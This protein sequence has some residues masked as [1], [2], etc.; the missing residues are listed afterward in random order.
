MGRSPIPSRINPL[1]WEKTLSFFRKLPLARGFSEACHQGLGAPK[2]GAKTF[3]EDLAPPRQQK[4][5]AFPLPEALK[6]RHCLL[7]APSSGC[8][9]VISLGREVAAFT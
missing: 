1:T 3:P 6:K 4:E 5:G 2:E 9:R 7:Y 8:K